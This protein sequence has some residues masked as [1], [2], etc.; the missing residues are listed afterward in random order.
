MKEQSWWHLLHDFLIDKGVSPTNAAWVNTLLLFILLVIVV[1]ILDYVIWKVLRTLSARLAK[2]TKTNFDNLAV[3]NQ[4]PRHLAH[5][6]PLLLAFELA[7]L[8]FMTFN[9]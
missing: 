2:S 7:P 1:Y 8:V 6:L 4:L 9:M 3:A 5:I